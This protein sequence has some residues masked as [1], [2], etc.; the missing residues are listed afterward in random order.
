MYLVLKHTHMTFAA[1]SILLFTVRGFWMLTDS[2]RLQQR[3]LRITPHII[4][5]LLL[6]S[7]IALTIILSQYPFAHSWLTAKV[8]ALIAYILFGAIALK[9]GK[10][11]TIR[12]T[13]LVLAW[14][15]VAYIVWVALSHYPW[16]WQLI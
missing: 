9:R 11:K 7:A 12:V 16:P 3:W 5:T 2:P 10:T 1:I 6:C 13:A 4:D 8:L 14:V 15:S